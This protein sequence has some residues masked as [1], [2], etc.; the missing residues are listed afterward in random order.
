MD[1]MKNVYRALQPEKNHVKVF[2]CAI[3]SDMPKS[4]AVIGGHRTSPAS[5]SDRQV[6]F[7][8]AHL[9]SKCN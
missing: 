6:L 1:R 3:L 4:N 5:S 7:Y 2:F 8:S 9:G